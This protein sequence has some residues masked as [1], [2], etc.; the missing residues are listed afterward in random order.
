MYILQSLSPLLSISSPIS[1]FLRGRSLCPSVNSPKTCHPNEQARQKAE[2]EA[3][4][5]TA[6]LDVDGDVDL[7]HSYSPS[8]ATRAEE[9]PA[10]P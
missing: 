4:E 8:V 2:A 9:T 5:H 10:S 1:A 3:P 7:I 6:R